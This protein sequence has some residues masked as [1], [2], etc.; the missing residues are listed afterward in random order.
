MVFVHG[1]YSACFFRRVLGELIELK[2]EI[3]LLV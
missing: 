3:I 1:S 2:V